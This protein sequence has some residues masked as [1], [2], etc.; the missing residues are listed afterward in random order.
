MEFVLR[1][2]GSSESVFI[3]YLENRQTNNQTNNKKTK[4]VEG[5]KFW[6]DEVLVSFKN[7]NFHGAFFKYI[8]CLAI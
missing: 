3:A 4:Q 5:Q 6:W 8:K 1:E 2:T 7:L